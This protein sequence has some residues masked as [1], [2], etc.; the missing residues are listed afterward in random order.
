MKNWNR[1]QPGRRAV[2][3]L[4]WLALLACSSELSTPV[5]NA[6]L[7]S[8]EADYVAYGMISFLTN[9]GVREGRVEADTAYVFEESSTAMLRQMSIVFYDELGNENATVTGAFGDWHR[10]TNRMVARGDVVLLIHGDSSRI[11]SAEIYYDPGLE[12]IWSDSL[13][14][15]IMSDGS[16]TSGTAFES[17]MAF[18]NVTIA[19]M[20][21]GARRV[22]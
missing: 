12:R 5:A 16:V 19:N 15:R 10:E 22:F 14:T 3:G 9:S 1:L 7:Q 18:E 17:D 8:M 6:D 4:S 2:A 11:E 20:R 13:T 21:G